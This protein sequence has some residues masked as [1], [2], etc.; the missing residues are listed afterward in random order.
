MISSNNNRKSN[1]RKRLINALK[2]GW[3]GKFSWLTR[4]SAF[5]I[6]SF[7]DPGKTPSS[8]KERERAGKVAQKACFCFALLL[9]GVL[10]RAYSRDK[11]WLASQQSHF[12][13]A[14]F[15]PLPRLG[16]TKCMCNKIFSHFC[17]PF[18][19]YKRFSDLFTNERSTYAWKH[20]CTS[21]NFVV[22]L[23]NVG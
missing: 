4:P 1:N 14:S 3:N 9:L 6:C 15:V 12:G 17:L 11:D 20:Y 21:A 23:K 8:A 19:F 16:A 18:F 13:A 7:L 10:R 2:S 5:G 22:L